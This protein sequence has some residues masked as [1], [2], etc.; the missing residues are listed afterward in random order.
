MFF[1]KP[2]S[3]LVSLCFSCGLMVVKPNYGI[4]QAFLKI[5]EY[6]WS[7][8]VDTLREKI[9][10]IPLHLTNHHQFP[11]NQ[12]HKRCSHNDLS[13][14]DRDKPW[15]EE[16]SKEVSKLNTALTGTDNGRFNDLSKM[17]GDFFQ[18]TF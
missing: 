17:T 5:Y 10:S 14:E 18:I 4:C 15:L 2:Q 12:K 3:H 11:N 13:L 7:G 9:L 6:I 8:D 16:G 1:F